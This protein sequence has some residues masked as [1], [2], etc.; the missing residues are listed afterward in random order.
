MRANCN[1]TARL[2]GKKRL[3][4]SEAECIEWGAVSKHILEQKV[5]VGINGS[6]RLVTASLTIALREKETSAILNEGQGGHA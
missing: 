4:G 2:I 3:P 6:T 1:V 5:K